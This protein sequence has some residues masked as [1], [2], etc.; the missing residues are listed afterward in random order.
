[1]LL[2]TKSIDK[3]MGRKNPKLLAILLGMML[4]VCGSCKEDEIIPESALSVSTSGPSAIVDHPAVATADQPVE[5][6]YL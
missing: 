1:M 2:S 3:N 4:L 5:I 6:E